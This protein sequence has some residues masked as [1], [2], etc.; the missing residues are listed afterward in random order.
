MVV[1]T[2]AVATALLVIFAEFR[3]NDVRA[4]IIPYLDLSTVLRME[5]LLGEPNSPVPSSFSTKAGSS[6]IPRE[7]SVHRST[8]WGRY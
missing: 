5:L 3:V 7:A 6:R 1:T 8:G 2:M 4:D